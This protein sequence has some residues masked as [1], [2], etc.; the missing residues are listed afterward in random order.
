M[1]AGYLQ[2]SLPMQR[3]TPCDM[4]Y[5]IIAFCDGLC[6]TSPLKE[7]VEELIQCM[8]HFDVVMPFAGGDWYLIPSHLAKSLEP[9]PY[10]ARKELMRQFRAL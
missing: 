6:E 4:V 7:N 5:S 1:K 3:M 9:S 2:W 8:Q 10:E